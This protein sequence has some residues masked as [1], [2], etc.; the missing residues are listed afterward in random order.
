MPISGNR[1]M[2]KIINGSRIMFA[3][4]PHIRLS[5]VTFILPVAWNNFSNTSSIIIAGANKNTITE[6]CIPISITSTSPVNI[7]RNTGINRI[8]A[9]II[10][11]LWINANINPCVAAISAFS[12]LPAPRW[13]AITALIPIPKPIAIAFIRFCSG[14]TSDNA[15]IAFSL[16]LATNRLSTML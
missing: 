15:V 11:T 14:Y 7:L 1:P 10:I 13:N 4:D 2:P 12:L 8:P 3:I 16:I 6:Y 5:M 9:A